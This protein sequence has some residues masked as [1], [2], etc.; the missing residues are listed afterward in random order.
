M[1]WSE[2]AAIALAAVVALILGF[3]PAQGRSTDDVQT[4]AIKVAFVYNFAKFAS[5]PS[6][7]FRRPTD[8]VNF[9]VQRG[10]LRL[11]AL[12]SLR[13]KQ[14]GER[15]VHVAQFNWGESV[16]ACHL[17]FASAFSSLAELRAVLLVARRDGVLVVSDLPDFAALGGHIGFV[18]DRGRLRFQVNL[19]SVTAADLKLSS[20]LLQL[21]EIVGPARE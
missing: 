2:A 11:E 21:A 9:C 12:E 16:E 4:A 10:D 6:G 19:R 13:N 20:Q 14:I 8:A 18:E 3:G 7:R 1:P 5:W 15:P 17:V